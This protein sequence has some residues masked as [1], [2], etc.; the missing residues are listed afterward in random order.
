MLLS[1]SWTEF[2]QPELVT[3]PLHNQSYWHPNKWGVCSFWK[4]IQI[5]QFVEDQITSIRRSLVWSLT[6]A[7]TSFHGKKCPIPLLQVERWLVSTSYHSHLGHGVDN[8]PPSYEWRSFEKET[9]VRN[10]FF[11]DLFILL[12]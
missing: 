9:K 1:C 5:A 2:N 4:T 12:S 7:V 6:L 8:R 3:A 10:F 11:K